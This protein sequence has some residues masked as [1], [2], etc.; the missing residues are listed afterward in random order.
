MSLL[1]K[2]SFALEEGSIAA[3]VSHCGKME[4]LCIGAVIT[5]TDLFL[6]SLMALISIFLRPIAATRRFCGR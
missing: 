4:A 1:E 3:Q 5:Y 2:T 6:S